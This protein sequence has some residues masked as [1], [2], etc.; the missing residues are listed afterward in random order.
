MRY[1]LGCLV[2]KGRA[3]PAGPSVALPLQL[4]GLSQRRAN[5]AQWVNVDRAACGVRRP[6]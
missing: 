4:A 2:G 1:C 3:P 6:S 5:D